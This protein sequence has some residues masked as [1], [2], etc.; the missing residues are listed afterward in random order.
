[1]NRWLLI[2]TLCCGAGKAAENLLLPP[3]APS[4]VEYFRQLLNAP[5]AER[6]KMLLRASAPKRAVLRRKCDDYHKLSPEEREKRLKRIELRFYLQPLMTR[7][8]SERG[9]LFQ[10]V[11]Q[12]LKP[13]VQERLE[14]WDRIPASLQQRMIENEMA[15]Q[16]FTR[17][18]QASPEQ[19]RALLLQYKPEERAQ[20][21]QKL[22]DWMKLGSEERRK[23]YEKFNR[24]F[25]LPQEE[26]QKTLRV[27]SEA[28]RHEMERT[29]AAFSKLPAAQRRLCVE[30]FKRFS[31]LSPSERGEFL[32]NA[33]R[34]QAMSP[35]ERQQ[36]KTLVNHLPPTPDATPVP[37]TPGLPAR[38]SNVV[39]N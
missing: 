24:F 22:S 30:S 9:E 11:P 2:L 31:N 19:Q 1:M 7:A 28:E 27:L 35:E 37:P 13:V 12:E 8:S 16:Y 5:E 34:W 36:W 20:L 29:L 10:Q 23:S 15:V 6:E 33:T 25:E 26:Q 32:R 17:L 4:P 38:G 21:E 18:K 14:I 39:G 3:P